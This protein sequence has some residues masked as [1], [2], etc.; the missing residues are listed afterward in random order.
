MHQSHLGMLVWATGS[1]GPRCGGCP[2]ISPCPSCL[3]GPQTPSLRAGRA[4]HFSG[5]YK[6]PSSGQL[7][8]ESFGSK[9]WIFFL[10]TGFNTSLILQRLF[11]FRGTPSFCCFFFSFLLVLVTPQANALSWAQTLFSLGLETVP[12]VV[13]AKRS[14]GGQYPGSNVVCGEAW[15]ALF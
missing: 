3:W 5:K 4:R 12:W 15:A 10:L 2:C 7:E 8:R 1:G 11:F 6:K 9:V 14:L 13:M